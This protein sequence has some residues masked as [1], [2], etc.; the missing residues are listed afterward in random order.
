MET[1]A[2]DLRVRS[3]AKERQ[4]GSE[5][6]LKGVLDML[7]ALAFTCQIS[8]CQMPA[9][10]MDLIF[11]LKD[12]CESMAHSLNDEKLWAGVTFYC[13]DVDF[14]YASQSA[15]ILPPR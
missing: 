1:K 12:R 4:A 11:T 15:P 2:P 14:F 5:G 8:M 6:D 7:Y 13:S 3:G 10:F 9:E